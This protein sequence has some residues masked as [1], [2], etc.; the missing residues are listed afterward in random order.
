[1][2]TEFNRRAFIKATTSVLVFPSALQAANTDSAQNDDRSGTPFE[3]WKR[4][5]LDIHH[6]S[7]GRGSSAFILGPDGTTMMIDAGA[8]LPSPEPQLRTSAVPWLC[9][10]LRFQLRPAISSNS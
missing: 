7:T 4:G 10:E 8:I 9:T 2:M 5:Y 6:I 3:P 1:M